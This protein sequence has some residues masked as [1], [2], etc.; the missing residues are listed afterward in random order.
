MPASTKKAD[1]YARYTKATEPAKP[2]II[3]RSTG[4]PGAG[5]TSFGLGAPGPLLVQSF[6]QGLE[7]VVERFQL[8][9]DIYFKEYAWVPTDQLSQD[10]A[11]DLRDEF[12]SDFEDALSS[13]SFRTILW[14]KET[15]IWEIF[16]Y[17]EFGAPNDAP[18][19]YPKLN[20][21]MRKYVNLPKATMLNFGLIQS[22]KDEWKTVAKVNSQG[23]V[24]DQGVKTDNRIAQ[25][26]SELEGLVHVNLH[27]RRQRV[28][29][30]EGL[31]ESQFWIDVGKTRGPGAS[32]VQD[33]SFENLTFV[34]FAQ[35]VFPDTDNSDWK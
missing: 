27:H 24:K 8:D 33:Q 20:Q 12:I 35:L 29:M 5:K 14:D 25:G 10:D 23:Q 4:E 15:D 6:D 28:K 21:R 26:F 17:A 2:R 1:L 16:R 11:K 3:W 22:M 31:F 19:N 32:A 7:G 18:R 9:K 30:G 34:D 13:G